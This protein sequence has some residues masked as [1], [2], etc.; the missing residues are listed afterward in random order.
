[1]F[2]CYENLFAEVGDPLLVEIFTPL[3]T[4]DANWIN[5]IGFDKEVDNKYTFKWTNRPAGIF[6]V[7]DLITMLKTIKL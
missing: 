7:D 4:F 1:M 2:G 5:W 6:E 3:V